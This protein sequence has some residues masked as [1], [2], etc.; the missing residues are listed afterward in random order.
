MTMS[1]WEPPGEDPMEMLVT[2]A[3]ALLDMTDQDIAAVAAELGVSVAEYEQRRQRKIADYRSVNPHDLTP[4][5]HW[6]LFR[7]KPAR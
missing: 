3:E 7:E 6:R 1:Y 5:Q 4:D 2:E